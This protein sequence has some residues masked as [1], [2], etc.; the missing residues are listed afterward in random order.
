M[1]YLDRIRNRIKNKKICMYPMGVGAKCLASQLEGC[2]IEIDFFCDKNPKLWGSEYNGKTCITK[3]QLLDM[4]QE[5]IIVIIESLYYKEIKEELL[6]EG[7]KNITRIYFGKIAVE[8]YLEKNSDCFEQQVE[9]VLNVCEDEK[10]KEIFKYLTDAWKLDEI[11]D[12]YFEKVY[13]KVQYFDESIYTI[14]DDEV[15]VDA[16]AYIGDT[17]ESFLKVYHNSFQGAHLFELDKQI[18]EQLKENISKFPS[19]IRKKIKYY[20][21]GLSDCNEDVNLIEGDRNSYINK[22][23]GTALGQVKRLDDVLLNERV[24]LIKMD[25]EGAET[26]A[27]CGAEKIITTQK[28]KLAICIYHSPEDMLNIPIYIKKLVPEYKIYI[29]HYTNEMYETVCYAIPKKED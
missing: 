10:S 5:D 18:Y 14:E 27:L 17:M 22:E 24:T 23:K 12:D 9:D 29:R 21:Y 8:D 7:I 4:D 11:A 19:D 13:S 6:R 1:K 3:S 26:A 28:P 25:I 20:P 16:G 15:L 2:G